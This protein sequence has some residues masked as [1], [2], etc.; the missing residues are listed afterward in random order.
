MKIDL[1]KSASQFQLMS[2]LYFNDQDSHTYRNLHKICFSKRYLINITT[3]DPKVEI[4]NADI[5]DSNYQDSNL[6]G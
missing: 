5:Y 4:M 1:R 2:R 3:Q 6:N